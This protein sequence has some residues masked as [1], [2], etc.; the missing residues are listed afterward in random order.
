MKTL[1]IVLNIYN[2]K[3]VMARTAYP[4]CSI[5]FQFFN[6][7]VEIPR[8]VAVTSNK[9]LLFRKFC[10]CPY[11]NWGSINVSPFIRAGIASVLHPIDI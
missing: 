11:P 4:M 10:Y 2:K 3:G 5:A 9:S 7:T 1:P 6:Q 8:N